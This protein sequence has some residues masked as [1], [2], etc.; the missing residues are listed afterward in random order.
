[1]D[2]LVVR[3]LKRAL[4]P[5]R[6]ALGRFVIAPDFVDTNSIS[7]RA[8]SLIA[9]EKIEGD[10]LEF[11][12]YRGDS[13]VSAYRGVEKAF[14]NSSTPG[15]WNLDEDCAERRRIWNQM[16][17]FAFDSFQGLPSLAGADRRTRDFA[18]GKYRCSREEFTSH[19]VKARVDMERVRVVAGW[20][21]DVLNE[22]TIERH[23][24]R[25]A[26]IVHIDCDL[27]ESARTVLRFLTPLVTDGTVVI[28][29]DWYCYRGHPNFGE[30][31]ACRE[32][33]EANPDLHLTE[34][35]KEGPWK[36]SFI[37]NRWIAP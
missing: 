4:H 1:V 6:T 23:C 2:S 21:D 8:A 17:F 26:A 20:F 33:L 22:E 37:V 9:A 28:F 32:W 29:D 5:I 15:A 36:N 25:T 19:L 14:E 7:Y 34:Y 12:V 11:G 10:Y 18:P 30:Q 35:Q 24:L 13:F 16:R 27:Y 3:S 31:K